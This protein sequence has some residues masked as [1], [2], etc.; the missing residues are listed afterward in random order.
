V[1]CFK[2]LKAASGPVA[3]AYFQQPS[4]ALDVI[5][6]TGTNGKTSS[7]WWVAQALSNLKLVKQFPCAMVG[8]LG[9]GMPPA[10]GA[11]HLASDWVITGLTTPDPVQLQQAFRRFVDQGIKAC[12]IEASSIGLKEHR[13][14]GTQVRTALFTNFTQ[15]HL[16]Y[17]GSM[18]DYWLAKQQLFQ[19]PG[20]QSAVIN[21]D[22][23]T[24]ARCLD[25]VV[26]RP[27]APR[28]L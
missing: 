7:A 12:A 1:S 11:T 23:R 13:L 26:P 17:H 5:A 10:P 19:W 3:A 20:L 27:S 21:V 4:Q 22:A 9:I 2:Q 18:A 6:I 16:D 15:D 8:T 24:G 28:G 25:G 14:D